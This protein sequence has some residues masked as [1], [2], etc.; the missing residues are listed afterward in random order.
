MIM[1]LPY[2]SPA[3]HVLHVECL[4][5]LTTSL[6][7]KDESYKFNENN[8]AADWLSDEKDFSQD[9]WEEGVE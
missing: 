5:C 4:H 6:G 1:K 2:I 3:Q 8:N 9:N 7:V